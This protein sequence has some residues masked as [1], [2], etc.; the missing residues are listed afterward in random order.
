MKKERVAVFLDWQNVYKHAREAFGL[1]DRPGPH[2]SVSPYRIA[3][4]LAS[5]AGRGA[6]GQ[7]VRVEVHRGLPNA[8][9]D[10]R[11]HQAVN[12]QNKAWKSE[13]E[14]VHPIFQNLRYREVRGEMV[15]EEKGV[16]VRLAINAVECVVTNECDVA[17]VFSHDTD[18]MPVVNAISNLRGTDCI[19][20]ASWI[21]PDHRKRLPPQPDVLNHALEYEFYENVADLTDYGRKPSA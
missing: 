14:L 11:G 15:A 21:S 20:T 16:D 18:L 5:R 8:R 19:E 9:R 13:S 10:P 12:R 17:I 2:G 1:R 7:L 6:M 3:T 4:A